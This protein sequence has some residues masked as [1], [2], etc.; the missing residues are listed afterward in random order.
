MIIKTWHKNTTVLY[1]AEELKKYLDKMDAGFCDGI[2]ITN[3]VSPQIHT[4]FYTLP[5]PH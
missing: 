3:T 1:A 5:S 2:D 4:E